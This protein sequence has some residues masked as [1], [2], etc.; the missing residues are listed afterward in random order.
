MVPICD[1]CGSEDLREEVRFIRGHQP[2]RVSDKWREIT[3][4]CS[5][6]GAQKLYI[7]EGW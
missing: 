3:R 4:R 1:V 6:C 2:G 7:E 5:N